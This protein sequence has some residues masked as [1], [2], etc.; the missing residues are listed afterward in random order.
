MKTII[1][2]AQV[3]RQVLT[4]A[5]PQNRQQQISL[6][7]TARAVQEKKDDWSSRLVESW[8]AR[9]GDVGPKMKKLA[10]ENHTKAKLTASVMD[11]QEAYFNQVMQESVVST[12][13][14]M[15]P[16]NA[17]RVV[18][19]GFGIANRSEIFYEFPMQTPK[20]TVFYLD[21]IYSTSTRG[22]TAGNIMYQDP[23]YTYASLDDTETIATATG[24]N[25]TNATPF[26]LAAGVVLV[27]VRQGTVKITVTPPSGVPVIIGTDD[28]NGNLIPVA[29]N[30]GN[31]SAGVLVAGQIDYKTGAINGLVINTNAPVPGPLAAGT[32]VRV[33]YAFSG[34][35][36]SNYNQIQ[37]VDIQLR[38][39]P[40]EIREFP[41][42]V[43]VSNM[44]KM[45]LQG[46]VDIDAQEAIVRN[47]GGELG[48]ALD[49]YSIGLAML[50]ARANGTN[51][52]FN[53]TGAVG[54]AEI[55][56]VQAITRY[57][58]QA[59]NN[60][61]TALQRG[62]VQKIV[63]GPQ[64]VE[65][66]KL[67][68]RFSNAGAQSQVNV[69][70]VG[71]L[72]GIDIFKAPASLIGDDQLL[73]VYK[74]PDVPEDVALAIGTYVPLFA[75]DAITFKSMQ[76]EQGLAW[77]GDQKVLQPRYLQLLTIE[78]FPTS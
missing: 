44:T 10:L 42:Y 29:F 56:R 36:P 25:G 49:F 65:M 4:G 59:G 72:D 58:S 41:L 26:N 76:T 14:R 17:L 64:A 62:G 2:E 55:D 11:N 24:T 63:G 38:A 30:P 19:L 12:A 23:N 74:N 5:A 21:P 52:N 50:Y 7:A 77:Y 33:E 22:S 27:P 70:K 46:T 31:S 37:E 60:M 78:N 71:S 45:L 69:Y 28:R 16:E 57:I 66:L 67:H 73:C 48:K 47:S 9:P 13:F 75:S 1:R 3:G 34:E 53:Y 6:N 43:I 40:F 20:D 61:Y 51:V 8:S 35:N 54:E 32:V 15:V 68:A 39:Y 18:Q